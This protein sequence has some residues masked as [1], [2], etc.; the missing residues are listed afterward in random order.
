VCE[1]YRA[2]LPEAPL[3]L[4]D[5]GH[6]PF[7]RAASRNLGV[8]GITDSK[9]VVVV[10]DADTLPDAHLLRYTISEARL[11]GGLHYP[12]LICNYLTEW[13]TELVLAGQEPTADHV[14]FSIPGAQGGIMV[15]CA[16]EWNELGGMDERFV[17]WGYE[18]NA[19]Y[20]H[21][22]STVG[23]PTHHNGLAWHLGHQHD[24]Y[25][26]TAE[27]ERNRLLATNGR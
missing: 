20:K 22:W 13:G 7:N 24:R 23:R 18:D 15:M 25:D 11:N 4:A 1:A 14:E 5:S 3:I 19:F 2:A 27:Q 9:V 8:Q 17:G 12:Y 10:G 16:K 6:V 21:V 26:G